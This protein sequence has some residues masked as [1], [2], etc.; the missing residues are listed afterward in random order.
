MSF[1]RQSSRGTRLTLGRHPCWVPSPPCPAPAGPLLVSP[2]SASLINHLQTNLYL[3]ACLQGSD[4]RHCHNSVLTPSK[5][6]FSPPALAVLAAVCTLRGTLAVACHTHLG[7]F[8]E[9][10][11]FTCVPVLVIVLVALLLTSP[12]RLRPGSRACDF[13]F[14]R[15]FRRGTKPAL[16]A[17]RWPWTR[18]ERGSACPAH[19]AAT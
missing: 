18:S 9:G 6:G 5:G 16:Q 17:D 10:A 15:P 8:S 1:T 19:R 4:L 2:R 13:G 11:C 7:Q 14:F 3:R 12:A